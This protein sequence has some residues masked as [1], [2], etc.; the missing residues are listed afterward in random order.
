[1]TMRRGANACSKGRIRPK[2]R[3]ISAALLMRRKK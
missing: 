1:M 2:H 3:D